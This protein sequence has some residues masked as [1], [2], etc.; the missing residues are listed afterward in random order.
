ME[1]PGRCIRDIHDPMGFLI[2][3]VGDLLFDWI[4]RRNRERKWKSLGKG[5]GL[6]PTPPKTARS[7][8]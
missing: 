8:P 3:L 4:L 5:K 1:V 2:E 7:R 6:W